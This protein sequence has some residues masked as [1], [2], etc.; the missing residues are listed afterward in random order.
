MTQDSEIAAHLGEVMWAMGDQA[1]ARALWASARK[2][3]PDDPVLEETVRR[4]L[5]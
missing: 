2:A 5:P 1:A 4:Y 3:S